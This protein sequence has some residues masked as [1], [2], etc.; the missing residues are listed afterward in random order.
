M[1]DSPQTRMGYGFKLVDKKAAKKGT[2]VLFDY[3]IKEYGKD[4]YTGEEVYQDEAGYYLDSFVA[5]NDN[6]ILYSSGYHSCQGAL[7][8]D[9]EG[10]VIHGDTEDL[11]M[12]NKDETVTP[13]IKSFLESL[14]HDLG[15]PGKPKLEWVVVSY[16]G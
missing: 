7:D 9:T 12:F 4:D 8:D 5:R 16:Y 1:G 11:K 14:W 15:Q 10:V 2:Q 13:E 6:A 3:A